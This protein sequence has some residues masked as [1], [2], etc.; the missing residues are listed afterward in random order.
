MD[1]S[2]GLTLY[3]LHETCVKTL[4]TNKLLVI[5]KKLNSV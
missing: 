4:N 3:C 5:S 1:N 2:G